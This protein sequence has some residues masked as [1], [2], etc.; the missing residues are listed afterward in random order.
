M[1]DASNI[2]PLPTAAPAHLP[3]IAREFALVVRTLRALFPNTRINVT[4]EGTSIES[5]TVRTVFERA[6][7]DQ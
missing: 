5:Q 4:V 2:T 1:T 7:R 3:I 6:M